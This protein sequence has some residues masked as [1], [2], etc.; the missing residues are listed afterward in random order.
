MRQLR[1]QTD[2][3]PGKPGTLRHQNTSPQVTGG[4]RLA[5]SQDCHEGFVDAPLLLGGN[6]ADYFAQ[7]S[8]VDG[9]DLLNQDPGG[10]TKQFDLRTERCR[11]GA[12]RRWRDQHHCTRQ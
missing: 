2:T 3:V 8:R 11:P 10:L 9:A 1:E 6:S 4:L 7:P 12:V 5:E